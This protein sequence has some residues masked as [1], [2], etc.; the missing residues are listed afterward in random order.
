MTHSAP[1]DGTG[2]GLANDLGDV[3]AETKS[4]ETLK[5]VCCDETSTN[6]GWKDGMFVHLKKGFG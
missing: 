5:C 3:V 4:K 1:A 6:T 2:R